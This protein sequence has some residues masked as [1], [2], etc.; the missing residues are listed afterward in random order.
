M[1]KEDVLN[2]RNQHR[3]LKD[4]FNND[5]ILCELTIAGYC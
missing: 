2:V 1:I 3:S 4:K 5:V